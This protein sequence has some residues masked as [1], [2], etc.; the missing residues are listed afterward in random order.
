MSW[1]AIKET[2]L[3]QVRVNAKIAITCK[4]TGGTVMFVYA[5]LLSAFIS[6]EKKYLYVLLYYIKLCQDLTH[7]ANDE[8]IYIYI[9]GTNFLRYGNV[10]IS[11]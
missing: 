7:S 8:Y 1:S 10:V 4:L 6:K 5:I 11:D 9:K 2:Q 3:G